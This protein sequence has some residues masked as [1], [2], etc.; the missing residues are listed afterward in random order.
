MFAASKLNPPTP[1]CNQSTG[2]FQLTGIRCAS[3]TPYSQELAP[4]RRHRQACDLGA[5]LVQLRSR[6]EVSW[7]AALT[8]PEQRR[9]AGWLDGQRP[10]G[11]GIHRSGQSANRRTAEGPRRLPE[12]VSAHPENFTQW[13]VSLIAEQHR[14][15]GISSCKHSAHS[16][17]VQRLSRCKFNV[18]VAVGGTIRLP[19]SRFLLWRSCFRSGPINLGSFPEKSFKYSFIDRVGSSPDTWAHNSAQSA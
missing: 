13:D 18:V 10:Q 4:R 8:R 3:L 12:P 17:T 1:T 7:L 11:A 5:S 2:Q 6:S 14:S 16:A 9:S 19:S 15:V